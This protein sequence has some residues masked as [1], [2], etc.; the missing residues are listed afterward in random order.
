MKVFIDGQFQTNKNL[1][2]ENGRI[3]SIESSSGDMDFPQDSYLIPGMIDIH[4]HGANGADVMDATPETLAT[5]CNTLAAEGVTGFLATTMTES[6]LKIEAALRNIVH[7]KSTQ[8]AE[9]LGVH[10]EGPFLSHDFMGAQCGDFLLAP[11]TT[12]LQKWQTLAESKIKLMTLAPELKDAI[13]FIKTANDLGIVVSVG[14]T[15][16]NFAETIAAIDAGAR[17]A[18][19]L[20]NAM[21]GMHHRTPGAAAAILYDDR[22]QAELIADGHHVVASMLKLA[23][24]CKGRD[25]LILVTDAMRAKC[26]KNGEYDLGGQ[27]VLVEDGTVRLQKN[28][29]LAGSVLRLNQALRNFVN[30]TESSLEACIPMVTSTPAELLNLEHEIGTLAPSLKANLVVLNSNLDVLCTIR[31]GQVIYKRS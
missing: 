26:L 27:Q 5:I 4:I 12:L 10:L 18:T 2:I 14:H 31:E 25:K 8:G 9:V 28:G 6:S 15:S 13:P 17:S 11:D 16:A 1:R 24:K 29:V 19:H 20:F 30:F 22:I 7:F 3:L 23:M 21:S